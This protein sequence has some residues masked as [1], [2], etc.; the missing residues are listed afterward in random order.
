MVIQQ[1]DI[2]WV[3]LGQPVGSEPGYRHPMLVVQNDAFN[4]SRINTIVLCAL[5]GNLALAQMP[6]NVALRK[7]EAGLPK[8]SVVNVTR[9]ATVDRSQLAEKIG[10]TSK[11]RVRE[12]LAGIA[13]VLAPS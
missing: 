4:R 12:V 1:G 6:G 8:R 13:T 3:D 10:T 11:A 7:G 2:F 9:I 5:T